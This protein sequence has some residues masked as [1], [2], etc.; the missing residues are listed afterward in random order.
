MAIAGLILGIT[1]L[2]AWI[3]P[4]FG[5]P[6]TITGLVLSIKARKDISQRGM[7]TAGIVLNI[8]GLVATIVNSAIG[9]Y[10]GATGQLF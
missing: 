9:A 6:I 3:I 8:I 4:I 5:L 1:G 10:L 2:L 7:S